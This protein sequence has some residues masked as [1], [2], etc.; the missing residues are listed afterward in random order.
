MTLDKNAFPY[1]DDF[2]IDKKY[3]QMLFTP[4]RAVQARELTQLQ[5]IL[6]N[7]IARFGSH[8]FKEGSMV[9]PGESAISTTYPFVKLEQQ[10]N[11]TDINVVN[12]VN[13][14]I[15]GLTSGASAIVLQGV[16]IEG[17][18]P[19]TL[20]LKYD[21]GNSSQ[22]FT[23][24]IS[25]G[26][27]IVTDISINTLD[28]IKVGSIVSGTNIPPNSYIIEILSSSSIKLSA[29][30]TNTLNDINITAATADTFVDGEDIATVALENE[31][32]YNATLVSSSATGFGSS[33]TIKRGIYFTKGYFAIVEDQT[34]LLDKYSGSPSFNIGLTVIDSFVTE[35]DDATLNDPAGGTTNFNAPG[36]HRYK[37]ELRL[38]KI[39]LDDIPSENFIQLMLIKAGIIQILGNRT[40]YSELEKNLA[41]RT[42]DESGDYTVRFFP[43][44]IREHL[45]DGQGN[46]G[47]Y[48]LSNGGDESKLVLAM[49]P[50]KAY[51]K[52]FEIET[53]A[54]N[55]IT[56]DKSRETNI[57]TD[58]SV[59]FDIG[60]YVDVNNK[61]GMFNITANQ[62]VN[63]RDAT[64]Y[65]GS[66]LGTARIRGQEFVTGTAGDPA[67]KYRLYLYDITMSGVNEFSNVRSIGT[68]AT[69]YG[70]VVLESG[71]AFIHSGD[72]NTSII[73]IPEY[74]IKE[75]SDVEYKVR[76]NFSNAMSGSSLTLTAGAGEIFDSFSILN[77]Q[78]SILSA[79]GT[80]IGNGYTNGD[81][82]DLT[83][84]GNSV[85]LGGSPIGKQVTITV[86]DISG[87]T[88]DGITTITKSNAVQKSKTLTNRTQT[89]SH[90][91]IIQLDKSDVFEVVSITDNTTT[92]DVTLRYRLDNGQ[93]DNFY[94]RGTLIFDTNY[95]PPV[96]TVTIVYKYFLHGTGDYFSVNSYDGVIDYVD[97]QHFTASTGRAYDLINCL[98]FRPR[99]NDAGTGYTG[100]GGV[101]SELVIPLTAI[102]VNYEFYLSR[103]DK[104]VMNP[105][106]T[107]LALTGSSGITPT[108]PKESTNSMVLYNLVIPPYTFSVK[109]VSSQLVDNKRYTMRDIGKLE[110]RINNLEY[111]TS[112]SLLEKA[113]ADLFIDDGIG[114]NRFKNGFIVDNFSTYSVGDVSQPDYRAALDTKRGIL[115]PQFTKNNVGLS[116]DTALSSN[117]TKTGDLITLPY[118]TTSFISQLFASK[119]ENIN[120]YNVFSW[121]GTT[122]LAPASDDWYDTARAPDV[123]IND[124]S[125]FDALLASQNGNVVWNDWQTTWT[126]ESTSVPAGPVVQ[127]GQEN[128]SRDSRVLAGLRKTFGRL[129]QESINIPSGGHNTGYAVGIYRDIVSTTVGETRLGLQTIAVTNVN[130]QT[131][132]ERVIDKSTVPFMRSKVVD[133]TC[134]GLRPNT[135]V[136]PFFD[137]ILVSSFVV[138]S[139]LTTDRFGDVSG[140]FTIPNTDTLKFRTGAKIFRLIDRNDN[141]TILATASADALY[142]ATGTLTTFQD[143]ILSTRTAQLVT[144]SISESRTNVTSKLV[145]FRTPK[146]WVD[147]LAQTFLINKTGGV[148]LSKIDIFFFSKDV[149]DIPVRLQIRNTVGGFPG[150]NIIPFSEVVMKPSS[151]NISSD[152]SVSTSFVFDSPVYL[153]DNQEYCFVLLANSD[154]YR[155]FVSRLG[156]LDILSGGLISSQPYAGVMFKSQN[157][158]TWTADQEQDIKFNIHRCVFDTGITGTTI[159]VNDE[160]EPMQLSLDPFTTEDGLS[161]VTVDIPNHGLLTGEKTTIAGVISTQ[162]GILA[163]DFNGQ[164]DVTV[165]DLDSISIDLGS[166]VVAN[167]TGITGGLNVTATR[168][169]I[170][171]VTNI[172]IQN[173]V[174]SDTSLNWGL[175]TIPVG[176]VVETIFSGITMTNNLEFIDPRIVR[177]VD[178]E[179]NPGSLFVRG[180][181]STNNDSISPV[182]DVSRSSAIL[183]GNRINKILDSNQ[184]A[185]GELLPSGG[186]AIAKY[187]TRKIVLNQSATGVKVF[188]SAIRPEPATIQVFI[189]YLSTQSEAIFDDLDYVLLPII[190]YPG[191]DS[192]N[193]RD[194]SF[195]LQDI[196]P[197]NNFSIKVVMLS[198]DSSE[199]PLIKE[200]RVVATA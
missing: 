119:T 112:L 171:D 94:T 138:P 151:V 200:F 143:T 161:I 122:S 95:A 35:D 25:T 130:N 26:S 140:T 198:S 66:T 62:I 67:A 165:I 9:I 61:T 110:S 125:G 182:I 33:A 32:I 55:Y 1:Y 52:G 197:F 6:Q 175:E 121:I 118:T 44:H 37:I 113:T 190:D 23:G 147:P 139:V 160:L 167:K 48:T 133:F 81:N 3:L 92:E 19:N 155:V 77:Y 80:A 172:N 149:N 114:N 105:D 74:A 29:A 75:F 135:T 108:S 184:V 8:V 85:V 158:S 107:F 186:S 170:V 142:T 173:I 98:D 86:P 40:Q 132:D 83:A 11:L 20:Y 5:T 90:S 22:T 176:N 180:L 31:T 47:V 68:S 102:L 42:F 179:L 54:T 73:Q 49:E 71:E 194:Y 89:L 38:T 152:G 145:E 88:I 164:H 157:A 192:S 189:K 181:L 16:E 4:G 76:R 27:S 104:L 64:T 65:G 63:L 72:L 116:L 100:P 169:A 58:F 174:L 101:L 196:L 129:P 127:K 187:V 141:N 51:I 60:N 18:D 106:G 150:S 69:E 134:K 12:F 163:A 137:D 148:F 199:V 120:P 34:I 43:M 156:E 144:N 97:V 57:I 124:D 159:F 117:Y 111:Y 154:K 39:E 103:K 188:L 193:L 84:V 185:E 123:V 24:D 78:V 146:I 178:N 195:E 153:H 53:Y 21:A 93:R 166:G 56:I 50:G 59:N 168:N 99:I 28:R 30:A 7:Q 109:D 41:R 128:S 70:D 177:S 87:S 91:S 14:K 15:I 46:G 13:K 131:I 96:T 45:D 36:A 162:N 136:Y 10:F 2:Q 17:L 115:R 79:S 191:F 183:V 82:I 126:G